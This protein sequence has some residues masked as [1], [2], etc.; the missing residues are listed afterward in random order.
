[1]K[2]RRYRKCDEKEAQVID[3]TAGKIP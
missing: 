1:V 3:R 2:T